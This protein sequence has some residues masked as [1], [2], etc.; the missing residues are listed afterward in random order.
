MNAFTQLLRNSDSVPDEKKLSQCE[1]AL[2]I[3]LDLEGKRALLRAISLVVDD[4][5][6]KLVKDLSAEPE[7]LD[8]AKMALASIKRSLLAEPTLSASHGTHELKNAVDGDAG[9]RWSTGTT[10]DPGMWFGI[11]L[12]M[13]SEIYSLTLDTT[14]SSLDYPRAYDVYVSDTLENM[15]EPR[16]SGKGDQPVTTIEFKPPVN[17]RYIRVVQTGHSPD[18]FWSI[19]ELT[20]LFNP[21]DDVLLSLD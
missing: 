20:V 3:G 18:K 17:G 2:E 7:L 1:R 16:V 11:D 9:S 5:S 12:H 10:M 14:R 13:Q 19:H 6:L 21:G 4:R 8:D 15:G